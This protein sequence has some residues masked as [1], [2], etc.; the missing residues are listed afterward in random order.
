MLCWYLQNFVLLYRKFPE[1]GSLALKHVEIIYVMNELQAFVCICWLLK[2][3]Q[4]NVR[5]INL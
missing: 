4:Y 1:D 2:L 5:S 3:I